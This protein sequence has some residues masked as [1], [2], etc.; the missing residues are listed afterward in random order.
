ML[1]VFTAGLLLGG[2][3]SALVLWSASGLTS[4]LP[5]GWWAPITV[6][7]AL[8]GVARDAGLLA[9]RLPQNS[10]QVPQ[11][12]LQR[13]LVRGA[14]QFG[15]EMGTG[16]RTYVSASLPYV[17]ALA[18]LLANDLAVAL[19]TGLGF[20]LG[21]AA[22]P[23]LRFASGAGEEWDDRL[24]DRLPLLK[25]GGGAVLAATLLALALR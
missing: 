7:A 25:V 15:F 20:A 19:L 16:V 9:L 14:L 23:A 2:T 12:V 10:R 13:D 22:T 18:V 21:R 24:Q 4:P 3:L 8:L 11:D 17:A 6:G 5:A 1:G